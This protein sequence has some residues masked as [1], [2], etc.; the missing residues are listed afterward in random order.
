MVLVKIISS[1][2]IIC[3]NMCIKSIPGDSS[4]GTNLNI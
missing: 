3:D 1:H 2:S 4:K